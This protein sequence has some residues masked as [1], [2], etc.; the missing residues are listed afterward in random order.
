MNPSTLGGNA[1]L[2]AIYF[3]SALAYAQENKSIAYSRRALGLVT[4]NSETSRGE[5]QI[6][7]VAMLKSLV[8]NPNARRDWC[9]HAVRIYLIT[10]VHG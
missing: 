6:Q 1:K 3:E 5:E 7:R 2:N 9:A 10:S 8:Q 4:Q